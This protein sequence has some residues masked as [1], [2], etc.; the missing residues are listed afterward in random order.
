MAERTLRGALT[1]LGFIL[2]FFAIV[3]FAVEYVRPISDWT[4]IVALALAGLSFTYLGL[5]IQQTTVGAPFFDG[6][7]LRWLRPAVVSYLLAL[8]AVIWADIVFLGL[9]GFP[10]PLKVLVTLLVGIGLVIVAARARPGAAR[11]PSRRES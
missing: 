9:D 3:Y 2:S 7:R 4:K 6:P 10:R 11:A 8:L 5:Y 1:F